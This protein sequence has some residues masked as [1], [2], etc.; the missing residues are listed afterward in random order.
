[1]ARLETSLAAERREVLESVLECLKHHPDRDGQAACS[2]LLRHLVGYH[3]PKETGPWTPPAPPRHHSGFPLS[4][5][6][7]L[8]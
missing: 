6:L 5:R 4:A 7:P 3:E 8:A 1:M 2:F